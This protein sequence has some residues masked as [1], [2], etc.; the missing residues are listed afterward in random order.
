[1]HDDDKSHT[2]VPRSPLLDKS[3]INILLLENIHGRAVQM[4][5]DE[6]Y[7][8]ETHSKISPE[9]LLVKIRKAHAIG[10]RYHLVVFLV[11]CLSSFLSLLA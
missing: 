9:E 7:N 3:A 4:L 2:V 10:V 8:V 1:M 11:P 5:R 6:G